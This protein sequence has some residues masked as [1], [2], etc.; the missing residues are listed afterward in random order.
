MAMTW[1]KKEESTYKA[2]DQGCYQLLRRHPKYRNLDAV[3]E[4]YTPPKPPDVFE[5][6]T[7]YA[8]LEGTDVIAKRGTFTLVVDGL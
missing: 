3:L 8:G 6:L 2:I 1:K 4:E 7:R 5:L